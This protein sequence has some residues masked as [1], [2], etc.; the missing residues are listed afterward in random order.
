MKVPSL[1]TFTRPFLD[2]NDHKSAV[3][4]MEEHFRPKRLLR[5]MVANPDFEGFKALN[6]RA[7]GGD[8]R[9]HFVFPQD[10]PDKII[11]DIAD[12]KNPTLEDMVTAFKNIFKAKSKKQPLPTMTA[13]ELGSFVKDSF[14]GIDYPVMS[15]TFDPK[16][17][18]LEQMKTALR[19]FANER[20]FGKT[21][22]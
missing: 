15:I 17:P 5:D 3:K 19:E 1:R 9:F 12:R 21:I 8:V 14:K 10:I 2:L 13:K 22:K 20:L 4:R 7:A 16:K 6:H 18:Y 11:M